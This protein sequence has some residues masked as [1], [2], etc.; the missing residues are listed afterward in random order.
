MEL[1]DPVVQDSVDL[2][3]LYWIVRVADKCLS[4]D[5]NSRPSINKVISHF[6]RTQEKNAYSLSENFAFYLMI[7]FLDELTTAG[8]GPGMHS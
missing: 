6:K 1:I 8:E 7:I 2:F 3:Q 4:W 5:P